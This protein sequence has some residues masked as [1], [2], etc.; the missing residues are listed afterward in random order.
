MVSVEPGST[1]AADEVMAAIVA[2]ST[3]F[4]DKDFDAWA[5]C[6]A[7]VPFT[8]TMGWWAAGGVSVVEGWEAQSA[9][10]RGAM[11]ASPEPNPTAA[12]VRREN[13][14]VRI[15]DTMAWVTF[16]Q[17]GEDT[18]DSAMDMPGRSRE[19]RILER[20]DGQWKIVYA[21]WLLEGA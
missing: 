3:A 8:R 10:I 7:H 2:E 12:R 19:T 21:G 11:Q 5:A 14:N 20:H 16:D 6:W 18:G 9:V 1:K 15:H 13:L 17:Y 4:W